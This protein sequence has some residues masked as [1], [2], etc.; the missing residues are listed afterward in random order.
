MNQ[1]NIAVIG[2]SRFALGFRLL[3][4]RK[5]VELEDYSDVESS[6]EGM[7]KEVPGIIIT[8]E[9]T[10]SRLSSELRRRIETSVLPVVV[11]LSE[12]ATQ[13]GLRQMIKKA[14]GVDLLEK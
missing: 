10:V 13:E 14:I 1:N 9:N 12:K 5:V 8:E 6:F 2:D 4:I 3:G 11:V 7:M